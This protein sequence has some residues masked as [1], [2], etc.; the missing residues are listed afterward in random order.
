MKQILTKSLLGFGMFVVALP[1]AVTDGPD[2]DEATKPASARSD[3]W[4]VRPSDEEV[5]RHLG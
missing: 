5:T 2:P 3:K 4:I 1:D